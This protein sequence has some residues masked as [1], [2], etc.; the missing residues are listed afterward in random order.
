[1]IKCNSIQNIKGIKMLTL[2]V[3]IMRN[4]RI[5]RNFNPG[6][7]FIGTGIIDLATIVCITAMFING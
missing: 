3:A 7:L 4:Y 1:M 5:N 2:S 6:E